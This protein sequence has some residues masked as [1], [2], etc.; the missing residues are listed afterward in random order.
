M[1]ETR[2]RCAA[3]D[4]RSSLH[5]PSLPID[6]TW[7][8]VAVALEHLSVCNGSNVWRSHSGGIRKREAGGPDEEKKS[9]EAGIHADVLQGAVYAAK[10]AP[11]AVHLGPNR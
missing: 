9:V 10:N 3:C 5:D 11:I 1:A 4:D 8:E 7:A 2:C 6:R